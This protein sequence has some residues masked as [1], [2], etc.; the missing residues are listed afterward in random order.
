MKSVPGGRDV[1]RS[2]KDAVKGLKTAIKQINQQVGKSVTKFDYS[3]VE[4]LIAKAKEV[5]Q[6]EAEMGAIVN[7]W[8]E[9]QH[10][11]NEGAKQKEMPLWKYY[12]PT[13]LALT[14]LGG[15]TRRENIEKHMEVHVNEIFVANGASPGDVPHGWKNRIISVLRA[16]E[17][18]RFVQRDKNEWRITSAGRKAANVTLKEVSNP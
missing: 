12:V 16:M 7:R 18:E 14:E 1:E 11:S 2:L 5:S 13:L 8:H 6:F 10:G 3:A 4:E 17:K 15:S 9:I